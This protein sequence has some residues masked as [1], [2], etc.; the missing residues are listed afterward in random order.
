MLELITISE[1]NDDLAEMVAS[2]RVELRSY[3]G[4]VSRT[5]VDAGR[6]EMEEYLAAGFPVFAAVVD[7]EYA[8]YVVCRIDNEVVWVESIFVKKEYRRH[9]VASALHS[10]AE[11]IA[12]SYGEET[13]Y[14]YV[15]PNNHRMI[16]FLRKRGYTVLNLIEIRKPYKDEKLTQT[17]TVG[18][19]EFDY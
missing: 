3:K 15:H 18:E 19:H 13:V 6:E 8:G 10:K 17:I 5:N 12:A 14:N 1:V 9:G 11:E 7:G 4:I 2:F 16:E